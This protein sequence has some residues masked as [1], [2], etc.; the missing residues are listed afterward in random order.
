M[1]LAWSRAGSQ[2]RG[3][4]LIPLASLWALGTCTTHI[5][6]VIVLIVGQLHHPIGALERDKAFN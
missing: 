5:V 2:Q 1:G 6:G 4:I 3:S